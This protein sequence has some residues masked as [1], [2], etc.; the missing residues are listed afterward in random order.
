M[1]IYVVHRCKKSLMHCIHQYTE[2]KKVFKECHKVAVLADTLA[3][4]T[5]HWANN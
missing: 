5:R 4:S 2:N 1:L 3:V